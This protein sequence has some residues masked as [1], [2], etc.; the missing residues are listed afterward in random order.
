[1]REQAGFRNA[2][3]RLCYIIETCIIHNGGSMTMCLYPG[4]ITKQLHRNS[5]AATHIM[6]QSKCMTNLMGGHKTNQLPHQRVVKLHFTGFRIY[7]GSLYRVPVMHQ[8][9]YI[10]IPPNMTLNDFTA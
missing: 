10:M 3:F 4:F 9:H 7:G 1:M 6:T 5:A 2:V 8:F